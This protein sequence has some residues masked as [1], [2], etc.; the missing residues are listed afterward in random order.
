MA[1]QKGNSERF[2]ELCTAYVL[3]SLDPVEQQEFEELLRSATPEQR[4]FYEDLRN[5]SP[6]LSLTVTPQ[7]PPAHIKQAVLE[8]VRQGGG[9]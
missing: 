5:T 3:G 2:E 9:S 7:A 8:H 6:H 1:E 4:H